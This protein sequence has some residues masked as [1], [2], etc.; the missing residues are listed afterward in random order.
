MDIIS[1]NGNVSLTKR[2]K[3]FYL[4]FLRFLKENKCFYAYQRAFSRNV[5]RPNR[6][7]YLIKL[8]NTWNTSIISNS[9]IWCN[10]IEGHKFWGR[11]D[12]KFKRLSYQ[13]SLR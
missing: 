4:F 7:E 8:C 1:Y 2:G 10:T 3:I 6:I 13:L 11:I 5:F 12:K 9:F